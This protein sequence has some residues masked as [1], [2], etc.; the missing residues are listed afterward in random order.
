MAKMIN[1]SSSYSEARELF[2]IA[3]KNKGLEIKS[4]LLADTLGVN[5]EQ[6]SCD[7]AFPVPA[8]NS[9]IVLSSGVH[10]IEGY[11]GS[12]LQIAFLNSKLFGEISKYA[13][14]I[15]VHA[16]N[17]HG[18][19]HGSRVNEDN[20]DINRNFVNF[21]KSKEPCQTYS[22]Y[23]KKAYPH[24]WQ[25]VSPEDV[26]SILER[27]Q[28]DIGVES[29]Q[30]ITTRGQYDYAQDLFY[31]GDKPTWSTKIWKSLIDALVSDYDFITHLDFH[32][33]LGAQGD[34]QVIYTGNKDISNKVTLAQQWL[35]YEAVVVPGS[36]KSISASIGGTLGS[37][38]DYFD[39]PS[40]SVALEF[41]TQDINQVIQGLALDCWL[42]HNPQA[43]V[44][45][46]KHIK[47]TL[48]NAFLVDSLSWRKAVWDHTIFY[49]ERILAG[50]K[51]NKEV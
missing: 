16:V 5:A 4:H 37:Y 50:L 47:Q 51:A 31:G 8:N 45:V 46:Q 14:V 34:C 6:L 25:G 41:G 13:D 43:D 1:I 2:L 32:T 9:C 24:N 10:G 7:I 33:G 29:M 23:R 19:S 11:C 30:S 12:G 44:S 22:D 38:L 40:V 26:L 39:T 42:R 36:K 48:R 21:N 28:Q 20:I 49:L 15:L 35:G 27:T 18:F 3:A 17:P